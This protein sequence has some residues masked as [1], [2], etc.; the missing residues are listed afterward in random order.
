MKR[1][2]VVFYMATPRHTIE[3]VQFACDLTEWINKNFRICIQVAQSGYYALIQDTQELVQS[4]VLDPM[5]QVLLEMIFSPQS[6]VSKKPVIISTAK[7][8][9]LSR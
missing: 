4:R 1:S 3:S 8:G 2:H 6:K 5:D 9:M 7:I